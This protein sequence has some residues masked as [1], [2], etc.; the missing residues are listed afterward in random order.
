MQII[1]S[2]EKGRR[3]PW[4]G[5]GGKTSAGF[6]ETQER[7]IRKPRGDVTGWLTKDEQLRLACNFTP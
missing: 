1:S 2:P 7:A 3:V 5:T 4:I 6:Y